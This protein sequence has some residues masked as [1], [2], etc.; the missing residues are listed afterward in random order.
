MAGVGV[1]VFKSSVS[2]STA[3]PVVTINWLGLGLFSQPPG[4]CEHHTIRNLSGP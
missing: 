2:L 4:A 1:M 3:P